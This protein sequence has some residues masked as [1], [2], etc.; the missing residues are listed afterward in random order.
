[1][2]TNKEILEAAAKNAAYIVQLEKRLEDVKE[3]LAIHNRD[4]NAAFVAMDPERPVQMSLSAR[5]AQLR[6]EVDRLKK[7]INRE[8]Y[9]Y[10]NWTVA[11]AGLKFWIEDGKITWGPCGKVDI[12]ERKM[13]DREQF[14]ATVADAQRQYP[15][16]R[17]GQAVFNVAYSLG[18]DKADSLRGG[19]LDP[20]HIDDRAEAFIKAFLEKE[21]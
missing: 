17:Y 12:P 6:A 8:P 18:P 11:H 21:D 1:M 2:A 14:D 4:M 20:F 15:S 9:V 19:P 13:T 3:N 7:K 10:P 5:A 16:W